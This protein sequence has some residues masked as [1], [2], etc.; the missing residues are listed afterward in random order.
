ME[1]SIVCVYYMGSA[2][3]ITIH[4]EVSRI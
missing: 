2:T 1:I 3:S 4:K